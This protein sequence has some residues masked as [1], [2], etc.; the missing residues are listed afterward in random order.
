[1]NDYS[2]FAVKEQDVVSGIAEKTREHWR[3]LRRLKLPPILNKP[4]DSESRRAIYLDVE[5][6]GLRIGTDQVIEL[7]MLPFDY[8]PETGR[9]TNIHF[10]AA[11]NELREPSIPIP[12]EA[13]AVNGIRDEDVKGKKIDGSQVEELVGTA[14][15]IIAHNAA[16]DRPMVESTWNVFTEVPWA[17]SLRDIDWR[18]EGFSGSS[19]EFLGMKFGWFF[20]GHRALADCEAGVALLA[21]ILPASEKRVMA[22]LREN[23][24]EKTY[25]VPAK[26]APFEKKDIL[27]ERGYRWNADDKVWWMDVR[28]LDTELAWLEQEIYKK[29]PSLSHEVI[30][31]RNRYSS[32]LSG[33]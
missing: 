21:E 26:G 32:T 23:A 15:L 27:R 8:E 30:T 5:A 2:H 11:F 3:L 28:E 6:T 22:A 12:A 14:S 20:D 13:T 31:A 18:G 25:R 29:M 24:I 33:S 19:L 10:D 16:Y 17:C 9:I 4:G 7:A 1:M